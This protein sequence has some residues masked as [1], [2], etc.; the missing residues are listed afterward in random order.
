MAHSH[1]LTPHKPGSLPYE[2]L[3]TT[4]EFVFI[5]A[6]MCLITIGA[7]H[8]IGIDLIFE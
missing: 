1:Y 5:G 8:M 4:L 2:T 3:A 6:V 7:L